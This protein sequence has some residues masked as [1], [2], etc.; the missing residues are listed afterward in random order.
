[1][2]VLSNLSADFV[3]VEDLSVFACMTYSFCE[4]LRQPWSDGDQ[5]KFGP[6]EFK[7]AIALSKLGTVMELCDA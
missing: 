5:L 4:P 6:P 2:A 1:M 7:E 3:F